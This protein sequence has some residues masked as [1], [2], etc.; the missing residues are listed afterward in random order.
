MD[1]IC[2]AIELILKAASPE[3]AEADPALGA[4]P[5]RARPR[6]PRPDASR[7]TDRQVDRRHG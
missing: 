4:Q 5:V 3:L 1:T 2:V 7:P 6:K